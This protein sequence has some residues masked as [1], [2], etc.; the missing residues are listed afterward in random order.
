LIPTTE[1]TGV[2]L[3]VWKGRP[4]EGIF[5]TAFEILKAIS[6][7]SEMTSK[8]G[9]A[10]MYDLFTNEEID[11]QIRRL[12]SSNMIQLISDLLIWLLIG[13][14]LLGSLETQVKE[15]T[16][17]SGNDTLG[18]AFSNTLLSGG[19]Q[20]L[21]ASTM[22]ANFLDSIWGRGKDWTPFSI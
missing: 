12:Y 11:P 2:P 3:Q 6:G 4:Q 20:I 17:T 5:L 8:S 14:L 10:G 18:K 22:D 13:T 7:K 1:N 16:K 19:T 21:K 15:Y 9:I